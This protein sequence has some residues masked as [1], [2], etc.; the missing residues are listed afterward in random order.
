MLAAITVT[1]R[2]RYCRGEW[3]ALGVDYE[4]TTTPYAETTDFSMPLQRSDGPP[5]HHLDA[6]TAGAVAAL[7]G[8]GRVLV[9]LQTNADA[10][11][12]LFTSTLTDM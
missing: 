11:L 2:E 7:P 10:A 12:Q 6:S 5:R 9:C 1:D 3:S 8:A 4:V